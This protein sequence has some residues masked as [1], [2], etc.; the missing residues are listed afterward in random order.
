VHVSL[1]DYDNLSVLCI[2]VFFSSMH[3]CTFSHNIL[4]RTRLIFSGNIEEYYNINIV[5][6]PVISDHSLI[7]SII[8]FTDDSV[9]T[10]SAS[11]RRNWSSFDIDK[12]QS[13]LAIS[14]LVVNQPD[15]RDDFYARKQLCFQRVLAIAILSVCPSVCHMGGSGKNGPS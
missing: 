13:D 5:D 4:C 10:Q 6:P 7:R 15:N 14:E 11:V 8:T 1:Y 12:F 9:T 2:G 3:H